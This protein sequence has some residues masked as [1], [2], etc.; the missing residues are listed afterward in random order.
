MTR[1]LRKLSLAAPLAAALLLATS[2][3]AQSTVTIYPVQGG[4]S[5]LTLSPAFLADI[6]AAGATVSPVSGAQIDGNQIA[7]G[8]STG[9]MNLANAEGQIVHNGGI[10]LTAGKMAV[11]L[12]AFMLSTFGEQA[13]VSALVVANGRVVGRLNVFDVTLPSD[14]ALPITP[15]SGDFF[16]SVG[17]NLDPAGASA[18]NEALGTTAFHDS[19]YVGYSLSLVLVP[20]AADPPATAT[21]ASN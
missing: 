17:W 8:L 21:T 12:D 9:E 2:T 15:K 13:Y 3:F 14:L 7:F 5:T 18:L 16:L 4:R 1:L 11:T 19:I 10:T 20:L 6:A